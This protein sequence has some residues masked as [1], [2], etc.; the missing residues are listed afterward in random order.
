MKFTINKP[1]AA[2]V[3]CGLA[4]ISL[5][6]VAGT[7]S[8]DPVGTP[9]QRALAGVGSDTTYN[10]LNGLSEVVT[11]GGVKQLASYD[12]IPSSSLIETQIA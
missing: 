8:A 9:T 6:A 11:I 3:A 10:V 12:P 5:G 1:I 7:A 2:V 4:M